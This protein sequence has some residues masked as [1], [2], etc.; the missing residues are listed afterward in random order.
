MIGL[1]YIT[2]LPVL[3]HAVTAAI[4]AFAFE[5]RL[6]AAF[7]TSWVIHAVFNETAHYFALSPAV[8]ITQTAILIAMLGA[9]VSGRLKAPAPRDDVRP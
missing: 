3:M 7:I 1:V 9:L 2:T 6:W 5:R 4:Y 8:A